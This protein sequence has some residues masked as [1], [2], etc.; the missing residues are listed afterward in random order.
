MNQE[1]NLMSAFTKEDWKQIQREAENYK[2]KRSLEPK[3][4]E[5]P[6]FI[7]EVKELAKD[8]TNG[9][10]GVR[11]PTESKLYDISNLKEKKAL[12]DNLYYVV[13]KQ[14][15]DFYLCGTFVKDG[16]KHFTKWKKY[17]ECVFLVDENGNSED[18]KIQKFFEQINQRQIFPNELVLD[19]EDKSQMK[20]VLD[21]LDK[22]K[23]LEDYHI[24]DTGSRGFH[25]H[26]LGIELNDK[27][28]KFLC[29]K[30]KVD[31]QKAYTKTLI[32]MECCPHWKT[33]R[34]KREVSREECLM[35][36]N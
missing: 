26:L 23:G 11:E 29:K 34:I 19:I 33:G 10:H 8:L 18:W 25:I 5:D 12:L 35:I 22:I 14:Q 15:Y 27:E 36:L 3:E 1:S 28:K 7:A 13:G 9:S 31:E 20:E 24:Y 32:A 2:L 17:S 16:N 30:F 6:K 21:L 4:P